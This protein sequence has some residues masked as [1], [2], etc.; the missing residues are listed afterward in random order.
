MKECD[1][2]FFVR[3]AISDVATS[4]RAE[5]AKGTISNRA[6]G[7]KGFT[8]NGAEGFT[9][10]VA[11]AEGAISNGATSIGAKG[12]TSDGAEGAEGSTAEAGRETYM[13]APRT[14][15]LNSRWCPPAPVI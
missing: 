13:M 3:G 7:A 12:A 9:S 1:K 4:N 8:S 15:S 14:S 11:E 2:P 5:G 10:D 6:E